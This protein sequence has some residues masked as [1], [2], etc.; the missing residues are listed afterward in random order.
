[1]T[2]TWR[3]PVFESRN[4]YDKLMF[5]CTKSVFKKHKR[6]SENVNKIAIVKMC[7]VI[8]YFTEEYMYSNVMC[9]VAMYRVRNMLQ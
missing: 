2:K 1:M 5:K 8:T 4:F 7:S 6:L 9:P 3:R